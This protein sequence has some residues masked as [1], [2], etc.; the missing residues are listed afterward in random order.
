MTDK[1]SHRLAVLFAVMALTTTTASTAGSAQADGGDAVAADSETG[2]SDQTTPAIVAYETYNQ[3]TGRYFMGWQ[4]TV[5]SAKTISELGAHDTNRNGKMD[6]INSTSVALYD[7]ESETTLASTQIPQGTKP[8]DGFAYVTLEDP[9]TVV[10]GRT[11]VVAAEVSGEP[12]AYGGRIEY[13]PGINYVGYAYKVETVPAL[14]D[15]RGTGGNNYYGATF[16]VDAVTTPVVDDPGRQISPLNSPLALDLSIKA[17]EGVGLTWSA[18]GLPDGLTIDS[19]TGRITGQATGVGSTE[20]T[21]TVTSDEGPS[22]SVA[23]RWIVLDSQA[24]TV[25]E[26]DRT[27]VLEGS[28]VTVQVEATDDDGALWFE[29]NG[30]PD[31]VTIDPTSGLISGQPTEPG[32]HPVTVSATDTLGLHTAVEFEMAVIEVGTKAAIESY[33]QYTVRKGRY[34]M[35]WQFTVDSE[36]TIS[37]LGA[38]DANRD[39]V[40]ENLGSTTVALFERESQELLGRVEVSRFAEFENGFAYAPLLEPVVVTPGTTY[41]VAS[42]ISGEG[43]AFGGDI[44]YL[45]GV[46]FEGYAYKVGSN[47]GWTNRLGVGSV[48]YFGASFRVDAVVE[49]AIVDPGPQASALGQPAELTVELAEADT[50]SA[51]WSATG[52][53]PGLTLDPD[54]GRIAGTPDTT[55]TFTVAVS[56]SSGFGLTGTVEF[57]WA[58]VGATGPVIA[59][60]TDLTVVESDPV[61]IQATAD[62]DGPTLFSAVGL[63]AGLTIDET[64]GLISGR[65][66]PDGVYAIDVTAADGLGRTD[67]TRFTLTVLNW[68]VSPAITSY[69]YYLSRSGQYYMGWQFTVDREMT[70][71]ELGIHDADRNGRI[72]N[73]GVTTIG[74]YNNTTGRPITSVE[75]SPDTEVEDG[76]AYQ[77][78]DEPVTVEPGTIYI[79]AAQVFGE[80]YAFSGDLQLA[81]GVSYA[82]YAYR[83]GSE[84]GWPNYQGTSGPYY[85]GATFRTSEDRPVIP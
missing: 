68:G 50:A 10:P 79:V 63:P 31:G 71:S 36:Q 45:E 8:E 11:Y 16:R 66:Q 14:P 13:G 28:E 38:H 47:F 43:Y 80:P 6:N 44:S 15:N 2:S 29:A 49:P 77:P 35:G 21:V 18:T 41:I 72:G 46:N 20:T 19:T 57:V 85:F 56:A 4:F 24:P 5:D 55:G 52:L 32:R 84:P 12:Y 70:I 53:P 58:V 22:S 69:R 7:V 39:G 81:D 60:M 42:E 74:L 40:L 83:A 1:L 9:V 78:L 17:A 61:S 33:S 30:L 25:A 65:A 75:L 54:T 76:F 37:E 48:N 62:V 82:G 27:V 34:F 59:P 67:T 51:T 26:I 73:R 3:R 23:F 64:T